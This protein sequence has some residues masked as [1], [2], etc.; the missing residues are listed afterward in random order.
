MRGG[1]MEEVKDKIELFLSVSYGSGDGYGDGYGYGSGSGYGYGSGDGSGYGYGSGYGDGSGDGYGYGDG[2]GSGYGYGDGSGYGYG[3]GDGYG[4]GYGSGLKSFNNQKVYYIDGVP[5]VIERIH[6]NLARG[7]I[8]NQDLTIEKCYVAKGND[9]FAHGATAKGA[10]KALQ[11][12]I[13]AN[14]DVDEKIDEFIKKFSL[15]VK[16]PAKDFYEWHH[17]LTGSCEFGRNAFVKNNDI[18]LKNGTYT[19]EE[20]IGLTK[21]DFGG[22]IIK[23]LE[24]KMGI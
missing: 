1:S 22:D 13:L 23:Q 16:Y 15:G 14:M 3:S 11:D 17:I 18:D 2:D 9:L 5:T 21:N 20:F 12:K 10:A 8:V 7:F 4:D 24:E 6:G 19:A